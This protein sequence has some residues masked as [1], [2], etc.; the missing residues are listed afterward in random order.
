MT[1]EE[2]AAFIEG[3]E[4]RFAKTM[5]DMPHS[6]VVKKDCRRAEEFERFVMHIRQHGYRARFGRAWYT[7]FDWPVDGVVHQF[8]TMGA[9]LEETIIIN[10]A[11]KR[12]GKPASQVM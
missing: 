1:P 9:S 4:W 10:R 2:I 12:S 8:W 5:P 6:Y 11:V 3:H 7:Y